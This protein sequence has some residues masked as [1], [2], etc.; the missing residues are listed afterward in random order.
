M[1]FDVAKAGADISFV[2]FHTLIWTKHVDQVVLEDLEIV[3]IAGLERPID[4]NNISRADAQ[5][6]FISK[7]RPVE[8]VGVVR[9]REWAW[10]IGMKVRSIDRD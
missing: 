6:D 4:P 8:L 3:P 1:R 5:R 10:F 9:H 2:C 7:A